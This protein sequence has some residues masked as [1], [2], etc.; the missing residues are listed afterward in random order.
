MESLCFFKTH[1]QYEHQMKNSKAKFIY[2]ARNST[3]VCV[4]FYHYTLD[5][6][7]YG[8]E[9]CSCDDFLEAVV[10]GDVECGD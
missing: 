8:F 5:G 1:F 3:D 6:P 7:K 9:N 4:S 2:V 10:N